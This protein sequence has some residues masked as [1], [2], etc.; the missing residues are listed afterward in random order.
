MEKEP[1][2]ISDVKITVSSAENPTKNEIMNFRSVY[3]QDFFRIECL[4]RC[5]QDENKTIIYNEMSH[6]NV[7]KFT[8]SINKFNPECFKRCFEKCFSGTGVGVPS[9]FSN[10][11]N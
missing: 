11:E 9:S 5:Y 2:I 10:N 7:H 8:I 4:K 3:A 1:K 6:R